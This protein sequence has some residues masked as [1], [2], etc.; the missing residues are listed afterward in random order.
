MK[1]MT[2]MQVFGLVL[3]GAYAG[4]KVLANATNEKASIDDDNPYFTANAARD[5]LKRRETTYERMIKP[6]LDNVLSFCGMVALLPVYAVTVAAVY[7]DDPGPVFFSQKRIGKDKHYFMLHKFRTMKMDTPHDVP[8]HLLDDPE[9]Y[10]TK[11][12]RFIRKYSIDELPQLWDCFRQKISLIGPRPA[13]WNQDDLIAER[14]QYGANDIRP[15]VTGWAQINGRDELEIADKA[16]LDGEY[17]SAMKTGGWK[18]FLMDIRCFFG[19]FTSVMRHEGVV[20][21]GTGMAE[22]EKDLVVR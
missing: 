16:R 17:V 1:K 18:A 19:T 3:A 5:D 14:E 7:L 22:R 11:V 13:L 9:Q 6:G 20:E 12:G 21:G 8:T 4:M 2:K 10:I 15:G